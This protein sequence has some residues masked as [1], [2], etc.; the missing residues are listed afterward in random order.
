MS[1]TYVQIQL[2]TA[3]LS[4]AELNDYAK[5]V[6]LVTHGISPTMLFN[7]GRTLGLS[8]QGT[9]DL[10]SM[11]KSTLDRRNSAN[12]LLTLEESERV[13]RF[14]RLYAK[15]F[16]LFTTN[17]ATIK[18]FSTVNKALGDKKP[19]EYAR[20]EPGARLVEDILGRI[21]EGVFS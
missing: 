2:D 13:L 15:A 3:L 4:E 11:S 12:K 6:E 17:E 1:D 10:V 8:G 20:T 14:M 7:F 19:I 16:P 9:A 5:M 18:W 21:K